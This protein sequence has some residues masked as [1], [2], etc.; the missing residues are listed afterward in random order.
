MN[1]SCSNSK[2]TRDSAG[3]RLA[4][5]RACQV[6]RTRISISAI[7][8]LQSHDDASRPQMRAR[9]QLLTGSLAI[10]DGKNAKRYG[11]IRNRTS[12]TVHSTSHAQQTF[13]APEATVRPFPDVSR[14]F[15]LAESRLRVVL[16][17]EGVRQ[18]RGVG[19]R[20]EVVCSLDLNG[21]L[22]RESKAVGVLVN[23]T[24][25]STRPLTAV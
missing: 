25:P 11:T 17:V 19:G 14:I 15:T 5:R 23:R 16:A 8:S 7:S 21:G 24:E 12:L 13:H 4:G 10:T 9:Q 6:Q 20:G 3:D 1:N 2:G 18:H 22:E